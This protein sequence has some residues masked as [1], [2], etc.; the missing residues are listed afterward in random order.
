MN[1]YDF[2]TDEFQYE[3]KKRAADGKS[4]FE[5]TL[6][7]YRHLFFEALNSCIATAPSA[8]L[9]N[10]LSTD[11]SV[12]AWLD[13]LRTAIQ[14]DLPAISEVFDEVIGG[15]DLFIRGKHFLASL[16]YQDIIDKHKLGKE[17]RLDRLSSLHFRGFRIKA[18]R[19]MNDIKQYY[20]IPF[21]LRHLLGNQR[22]SFSGLPILYIGASI[23]DIY[24]ELDEYDL[25][26][27]QIAIAS[28][29]VNPI[30][31]L[32]IHT[33]YQTVQPRNRIFNI[34]NE[35]YNLINDVFSRIIA[36]GA[37]V[38]PC[39]DERIS[40]NKAQLIISF[41]KFVISQLCTFPKKTIGATFYEEYVI[42]Q[43]FTEALSLHKYDGVIFPSTKFRERKIAISSDV[44]N[45]FY[46]ENI[47]MFS[48]YSPTDD[49]DEMLISNF[50]PNIVTHG[51][52]TSVVVSDMIKE[53]SEKQQ[54]L[55][56]EVYKKEHSAGKRNINDA[57]KNVG[58]K[59][60]AYTNM[61]IDGKR[62][63]DT[64][65]GK[66]ELLHLTTYMDYLSSQVRYLNNA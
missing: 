54:S 17:E 41:R 16:K 63:L 12:V 13:C 58:S 19:D 34:T 59:L 56:L 25:D 31:Y 52:H 46:K 22:F 48:E 24:Y 36:G 21:N 14:E 57:I 4:R 42:P 45:Y 9:N 40:P 11:K 38:P 44:Q 50:E 65:A 6:E 28:F 2:I 55:T 61:V 64:V 23:A 27:D 7:S 3:L 60:H 62:Y 53:I 10:T 39:D 47:A 18:G 30:A 35:I 26:N 1:I 66:L 37:A 51:T 33:G 5:S 8:Y 20:H 43:L 15:Y 29:A 32:T 49:Y